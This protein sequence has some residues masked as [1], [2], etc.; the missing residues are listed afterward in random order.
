MVPLK[1]NS[2]MDFLRQQ[3]YDMK[4][5]NETQQLYTILNIENRE[6]PL[7]IK[8]DSGGSI[9][10]CMLF[11]PC[12]MTLKAP[13]EVA[14]LLLLLNKEIDLPGFGMDETAKVIFYRCVLPTTG[15][16]DKTLLNN[17]MGAL[18]RIARAF[19]PI[20]ALVATGTYFESIS[21]QVREILKKFIQR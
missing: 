2:L 8:V 10:Q 16:I 20:I 6:F 12:T 1:I 21:G 14:R 3:K 5:Q 4:L 19:Y 15:S 11:M 13:P 17:V 18:P 7:F 9:L